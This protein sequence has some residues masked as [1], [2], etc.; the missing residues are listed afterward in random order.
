MNRTIIFLL[1]AASLCLQD[2]C[3]SEALSAETQTTGTGYP[4]FDEWKKKYGI[5]F[6]NAEQEQSRKLIYQQKLRDVETHNTMQFR[7]SVD[8][9]TANWKKAINRFSALTN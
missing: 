8:G 7:Q 1:L 3:Q 5:T 9:S 4:S 2:H 6:E